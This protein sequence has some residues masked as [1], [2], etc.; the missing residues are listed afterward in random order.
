MEVLNKILFREEK[1]Q[2][3]DIEV[4]LGHPELLECPFLIPIGDDNYILIEYPISMVV[5]GITKYK[6]KGLK[7]FFIREDH[8]LRF[9]TRIREKLQ[10]ELGGQKKSATNL[11]DDFEKYHSIVAHAL[12]DV[13]INQATIGLAKDMALYVV[14]VAQKNPQFL[15]MLHSF[16]TRCQREYSKAMCVSYLVS[17]MLDQCSWNTKQIQ[18]K[19]VLA[20]LLSDTTLKRQDFVLFDPRMGVAPVD[21]PVH[22]R[23]HPL[24]VASLLRKHG[25]D[26]HDTLTVIEEH[27]ELPDGTGFP[28]QRTAGVISQ[29]SAV[30]IVARHF[31]EE[32]F[33][34]GENEFSLDKCFP[35]IYER[36]QKGNFKQS[37]AALFQ[38]LGREKIIF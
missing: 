35:R 4:A 5:S 15:I 2:L 21:F 23:N 22:V 25:M 12:S 20:S 28:R 14:Q 27:H 26:E 1:Y 8:Y 18:E 32:L 17:L 16:R 7:Y 31:V 3:I 6:D 37:C 9:L 13:G 24:E 19:V 36:F 11:V 29:L 30:N 34:D 33:F 10:Y 38:V